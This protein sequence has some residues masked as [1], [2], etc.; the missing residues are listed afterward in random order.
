MGSLSPLDFYF[1]GPDVE[2]PDR[3]RPGGYH[4]VHLGDVY[5]QRYRVIHKLGFGTYSTVWLARDLQSVSRTRYVAL[6]FAVAELTGTNNEIKIYRH[7]ASK[8][9][10]HPGSE[11]VLALLD[12]FRVEGPN[13]EHDVLVSQVVGPELEAVFNDE[14]TVIQQSIK[15]LMHQV[16]LGTSFLHHCGVVHADL[17]KCNIA[18]EI[19][20]LDGKAEESA[21]MALEVP[22]CVAVLTRDPQHHTDLLPKYLV[23]P[24][25]LMDYVRQEDMKVKIID[26]GEAFFSAEVPHDLHSPIQIR[27]PEAILNCL[28]E[29]PRIRYDSRIDVWSIGCLIYELATSTSLIGYAYDDARALRELSILLGPLPQ[30]WLGFLGESYSPSGRDNSFEQRTESHS[31][32]DDKPGTIALL[33]KILILDPLQRPDVSSVL[34][35]PWFVDSQNPASPSGSAPE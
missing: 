23:I 25:N 35:D 33:Q 5:H 26:F 20:D 28:L 21:M 6:K 32:V 1:A 19:P 13:G 31:E 27:P 2:S 17:H 7:L 12:H 24:G 18:V 9:G 30:E 10:M 11:R 8:A 4:P 14:P 34:D 29:V 16:A 3:Y 22:R 15:S